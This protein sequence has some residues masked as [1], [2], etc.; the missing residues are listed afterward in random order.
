MLLSFTVGNY[1]SYKDKKTLSLEAA[2]IKEHEAYV[3]DDG[4]HHILP[5]AVVYGA[6][7][8]GKSNLIE[9]FRS[10]LL[11]VFN[12]AG[13][14]SIRELD[15]YPFLYSKG[16]ES[17][18]SYFE[19]EL[20]IQGDEYRYGFTADKKAVREE[21][22]YM[23]TDGK[24][25]E[26]CLFEREG[27][28]IEVTSHF[29]DAKDLVENTKSTTLF[30]S[31]ADA[32]NKKAAKL[33]VQ[34]LS[35]FVIFDGDKVKELE[36]RPISLDDKDLNAFLGQFKLGFNKVEV[37]DRNDDRYKGIKAVTYHNLFDENGQLIGERLVNMEGAES[38]GTNKLFDIA[39]VIVKALSVPSVIIIDELDCSLHP[40]ITRHLIELFN[41]KEFN[42]LRS[43]LIF[44]T[45][46]TNLLDKKYFRR[47]QIWFTEKDDVG[48]TD[49][50]S[51]VEFKEPGG[52]K[53]RNDRSYEKDYINGRYGA[54]P[55]L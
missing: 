34:E 27:D 49:L 33:I 35:M 18:P 22:L 36:K 17:Q 14:N 50:Y 11:M 26:K 41:N 12:S 24:G 43:Q 28:K 37:P 7:S 31:A 6:N 15:M 54:I 25:R 16:Y 9:A 4:A 44:A 53:V 51:L 23:T 46:D 45:H 13:Y 55:Y 29:K 20:L 40:F 48:G 52:G 39:P 42:P 8:S 1:R 32:F 5:C 2:A 19:I 10:F 30:L 38:N 3:Y 21:W 47:D